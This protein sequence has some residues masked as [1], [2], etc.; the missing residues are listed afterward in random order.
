MKT[1]DNE[2]WTD[3]D[4]VQEVIDNLELY[5]DLEDIEIEET[6]TLP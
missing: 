2:L 3:T 1:I 4:E 5:I 6:P